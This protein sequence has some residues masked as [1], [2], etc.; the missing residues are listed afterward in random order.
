MKVQNYKL[1]LKLQG[2]LMSIIN[3]SDESFKK[4]VLES[5]TVVLVDFFAN[6]CAPCKRLKPIIEELA[7]TNKG[8]IKFCAIDVEK[9]PITCSEY[10][11][12]ALPTL[13]LYKNGK[14]V[15]SKI[16]GNLSKLQLLNFLNKTE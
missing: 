7:N 5:S 8:S 14:V 10:M 13:L 12:R 11:V 16:G 2:K 1:E 4:E 3:I 6:W 15:A 9:N